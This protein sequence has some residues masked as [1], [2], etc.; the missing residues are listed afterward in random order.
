MKISS[1]CSSHSHQR[2]EIGTAH[3]LSLKCHHGSDTHHFSHFTG[4]PPGHIL[5]MRPTHVLGREKNQKYFVQQ[6]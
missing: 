2:K 4:M 1:T 6:E 5:I 3:G